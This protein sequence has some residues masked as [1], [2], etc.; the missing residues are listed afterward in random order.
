MTAKTPSNDDPDIIEGVAVEKA[1]P[2]AGRGRRGAKAGTSR[3][4]AAAERD[5]TAGGQSPAASA[6][7]SRSVSPQRVPLVISALALLLVMAL[8]GYQV[9]TAESREAALQAEIAA[10]AGQ[11]DAAR[12]G[13]A[14]LREGGNAMRAGQDGLAKRL[15]GIE[16]GLPADPSAAIAALSTRLEELEAAAALPSRSAASDIMV[17]ET[18]SALAHAA[19][20]ALAA[21]TAADAGGGDAAQWLPVL[22]LASGAGLDLGD[23]GRLE[24]LVRS[25]PP[26]SAVLLAD[27]V[28]L[29][30]MMRTNETGAE[31]AGW[32]DSATGRLGDFIQLRRSD[33]G[34]PADRAMDD[35]DPLSQWQRA[36]TAG[37]LRAALQASNAITSPPE[38]LREWQQD[39][40]RRLEL[41]ALL[42]GMAARAISNLVAGGV[43][44]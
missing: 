40:A 22:S 13:L 23:L 36:A 39:V 5:A 19:M 24:M 15:A 21:M 43:P 4:K 18:E 17:M 20:A 3:R 10:I 8:A 31:G 1:A 33:A 9:W 14:Q 32:W 11:L 35:D 37:G 2:S 41:D 25:R 30:D 29:A 44:G 12:D 42:S 6:D 16:A 7:R 28:P 38:R 34:V 26:S 27:V